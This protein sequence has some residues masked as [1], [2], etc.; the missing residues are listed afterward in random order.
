MK[1]S[2]DS[3]IR[4]VHSGNDNVWKLRGQHHCEQ[5]CGITQFKKKCATFHALSI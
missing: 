5:S 2:N 4:G 1:H 3:V